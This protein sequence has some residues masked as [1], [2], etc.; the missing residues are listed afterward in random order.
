MEILKLQEYASI[1][2]LS[3]HSVLAE[4]QGREDV[5]SVI[6]HLFILKQTDKSSMESKKYIS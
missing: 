3:E 4:Q 6:S 5:T 1:F 2:S